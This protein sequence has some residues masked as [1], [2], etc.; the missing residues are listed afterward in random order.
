MNVNLKPEK[1]RTITSTPQVC[2]AVISDDGRWLVGGGFD[3]TLRR[4]DLDWQPLEPPL[5][6]EAPPRRGKPSEPA[7]AEPTVELHEGHHGWIEALAMRDDMLFSADS[8]GQLRRWRCGEQLE[9][10]WSVEQA[11]DGWLRALAFSPDG[12]T[13]AT[14]GRDGAARIWSTAAGVAPEKPSRS[15]QHDEDLYSLAF[16]TDGRL[17]IGDAKGGIHEWAPH[18]DAP[19]RRLNAS[20]LHKYDRIQDVG[21]VKTLA[22]DGDGKRL[23]AAGAAPDHGGTVQG[24]PLLLFFDLETG[25]LEHRCELGATKDGYVHALSQ[26]P[27]GFWMAV[28]CGTPGT[29]QL[30]FVAP[31]ADEPFFRDTKVANPH[32]LHFCSTRG[33][34]CLTTTNKGSNGNGRRLDANG[35]YACN[36][37]PIEFF[38]LVEQADT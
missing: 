10:D 25:K 28:T 21:G 8:W 24:V 26:H 9:L 12:R 7:V 5:E 6:T 33:L 37:T 2:S 34:L 13:I 14:C 1:Q 36:S 30:L 20:A 35:E 11:H 23:V 29:G 19:R 17:F 32:S 4:W 38:R 3:G 31:D 22:I 18:D 16:H 15:W 27:E